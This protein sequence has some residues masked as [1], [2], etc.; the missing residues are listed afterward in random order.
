MYIPFDVYAENAVKMVQKWENQPKRGWPATSYMHCLEIRKQM[1]FIYTGNGSIVN[2][3]KFTEN[4]HSV[5]V[6]KQY[7]V[8]MIVSLWISS[9]NAEGHIGCVRFCSAGDIA[10]L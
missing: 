10:D 6:V 7:N 2:S 4:L 5:N 8:L 3:Q 1:I 9:H